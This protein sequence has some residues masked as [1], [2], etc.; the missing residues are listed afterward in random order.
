MTSVRAVRGLLSVFA[1]ACTGCFNIRTSEVQVR[2]A[3]QVTLETPRG[4]PLLLPGALEAS[5]DK[6]KY[7][8]FL[9]HEDYEL[10]AYR[11]PSGA[12]EL[13]CEAC[14]PGYP[15]SGTTSA[16]VLDEAGR[17][18]PAL[19]RDVHVGET[20]TIVSYES[21]CMLRGRHGC[22]VPIHARLVVP[23]SDVVEIRRRVEPARIWGYFLLGVSALA[24]GTLSMW[25]LTPSHDDSIA[26]RAPLAAG[27]AVPFLALG[28]VGLWHVLASAHE[29]V[30][31]PTPP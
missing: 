25:A 23:T 17:T 15:F 26:R 28:G 5:V 31:R 3:M 2:D 7:W 16:H 22:R 14:D 20:N 9:S 4:A 24:V 10:R 29:D 6:G 18:H 13:R 30:W 19:S 21:A 8:Y 1:L 12:I 27:A 11:E